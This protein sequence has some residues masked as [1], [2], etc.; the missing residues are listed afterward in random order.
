MSFQL[1]TTLV[2]VAITIIMFVSGKVDYGIVCVF[3][4]VGLTVTGVMTAEQALAAFSN[5]NVILFGAMFIVGNGLTKTGIVAKISSLVYRYKDNPKA[6]IA[7]SCISGALISALVNPIIAVPVLLPILIEL[8]NETGISRSKLLYPM[9][10]C[11]NVAAAVTIMGIGAINPISNNMMM[12]VGGTIPLQMIDFTIARTPFVIITILY[13]VFIGHKFLPDIPNSSFDDQSEVAIGSFAEMSKSKQSIA[14]II[15]IM[16]ICC[17]FIADY[18]HIGTWIVATV[19]AAL[20]IVFG[21]L[22][23]KE[24]YNSI[25]PQTMFLFVGILT[26]TSAMAVSGASDFVGAQLTSLFTSGVNPYIVLFVLMMVVLVL[27]QLM[28]NMIIV[29]FSGIVAMVCVQL[30]MDP[31]AAVMGVQIAGCASI[32]TPMASP[33]QAMIAIPGKY[34]IKDFVKAGLPVCIISI[35]VATFFLPMLFPFYP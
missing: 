9:A 18:I 16:T 19:G 34:T 2:I 25:N 5:T 12:Q 28:S 1:I 33:V 31:R 10:A 32:L 11:V 8:A 35:V 26:L 4:V 20:F 6:L 3:N 22:S 13:F 7:I 23:P 17:L 15:S 24:A 29:V 21:I 14:I 27:T 30:G